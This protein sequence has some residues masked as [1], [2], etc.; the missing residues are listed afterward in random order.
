MSESDNNA[1]EMRDEYDFSDGIAGKH[2]QAYRAGHR[3]RIEKSDGTMSEH[4]FSLEDG[5]I[6]LDPD[7]KE[8]FPDSESVNRALRSLMANG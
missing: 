8:R 2:H 4:Y 3:V 7:L 5:A 1:G 6:M